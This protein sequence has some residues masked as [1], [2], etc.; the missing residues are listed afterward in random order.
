VRNISFEPCRSMYFQE[1]NN[2]CY[3]QEGPTNCSAMR[4]EL[5]FN[6][7]TK[8]VSAFYTVKNINFVPCSSLYVQ[9]ENYKFYKQEGLASCSVLRVEFVFKRNT[10]QLAGY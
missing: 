1:E 3:K 9:E 7:K 6:S 5:A 10:A 4:L 2:K 8:Y